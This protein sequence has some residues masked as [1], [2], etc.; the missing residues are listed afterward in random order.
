[1]TLQVSS[2]DGSPSAP[3][4]TRTGYVTVSS[5]DRLNGIVTITSGNW[6]D[7]AN[8][9]AI[10]AGDNI[11]RAGNYAS[12]IK[13]FSGWLPAANPSAGDSWFA[14]NRTQDPFRLA[15][16][17]VVV[18]GLSPREGLMTSAMQAFDNG[19][20]PTHEFRNTADYLNLQ[21]ELQSAGS[22][23]VTKEMA[24]KPTGEVFGLPF[25]GLMVMGPVGPIK[26]FPDY[27]CQQGTGYMLQLDTWTLAGTGDF[28][29]I[30][31]QDGN[32]ILREASA[33]SYEGRIVG[34]LQFYTEAPGYNVRATL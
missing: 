11:F 12:V 1:M 34:D 10:Q 9:P 24:E 21:L 20:A 22:L 30:D 32:R 29:Y 2:D 4:G 6:S 7:P 14:V 18:T 25:E 23:L 31:A 15:G 28:P 13:G 17:R 26:I 8:I 33:D 27:N 3:A 5:V 16:V 19:G